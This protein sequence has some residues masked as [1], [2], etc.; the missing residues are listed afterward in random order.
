MRRPPTTLLAWALWA[1]LVVLWGAA[2]LLMTVTDP[3]LVL[4]Q[5]LFSPAVL[6]FPT[7]GALIASRRPE[8][9]VGWLFC[10]AP[11]L[12]V[13]GLVSE[14]CFLYAVLVQPD[15]LVA[16]L[17]IG[18]PGLLV[19]SIGWGSR[20]T[21]TLLLFPTGRLPSPR[22]RPVAWAAGAVLALHALALLLTSGPLHERTPAVLNPLGLAPAAGVL[23]AI[24]ETEWVFLLLVL[25]LTA[26][27]V[28]VYFG[29]VVLLQALLRP[30]LGQESD[31]AI[32][33]STLASATLFQPLRALSSMSSGCRCLR[34]TTTEAARTSGW[35]GASAT[36]RSSQ[37]AALPTSRST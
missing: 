10:L 5:L 36:A 25:V 23:T 29:C 37:V 1:L 12:T 20:W 18:L 19:G 3:T 4:E 6:G 9:T 28:A 14:Q 26:A 24:E 8:N 32:I 33:V 2:L 15:W 16:A 27:L 21:F 35:R 11:L 17:V 34:R 30:L 13:V 31:L 7:V 22:W